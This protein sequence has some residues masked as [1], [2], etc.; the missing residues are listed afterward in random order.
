MGTYHANNALSLYEV[1]VVTA[2]E[3]YYMIDSTHTQRMEQLIKLIN[4]SLQRNSQMKVP[5][6]D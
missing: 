6:S 3:T 4:V 5:H 1:H 2:K